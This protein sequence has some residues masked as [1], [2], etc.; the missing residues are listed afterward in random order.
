[1]IKRIYDEIGAK[2]L[3]WGSDMPNI[4][5]ACTY[6]QCIDLVKIHFYFMSDKEKQLVLGGTAAKLYGI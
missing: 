5:R 2:R 3:I 6:Q 1:M 4:Y